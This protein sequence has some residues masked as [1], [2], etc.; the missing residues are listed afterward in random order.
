MVEA[1]LII[2]ILLLLGVILFS[3]G[4]I[5]RRRRLLREIADLREESRML[6][7][8]NEALRS[9]LGIGAEERT[10][11]FG[12][13]LELVRDLESLRCAIEGAGR[14]ELTQKYGV[15][16]GPELLERILAARPAIDHV[17]KWKLAH[18]LLVGEVGR[19]VMQSLS[20]GAPLEEAAS[21]AGVP[22]VVARRQVTRLQTLGYLDGRLKPTELGREALA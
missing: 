18:E 15:P 21:D 9:G 14:R 4:G 22:V 19:M 6:V 1:L 12:E 5:V 20:A 13:M 10:K 8:A 2:I 3:G 11:R 17:A 16:P 7:E